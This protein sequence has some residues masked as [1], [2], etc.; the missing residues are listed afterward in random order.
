M[1]KIFFKLQKSVNYLITWVQL[2]YTLLQR[3][4][5]YFKIYGMHMKNKITLEKIAG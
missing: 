1:F 5:F 3:L 2:V 4:V